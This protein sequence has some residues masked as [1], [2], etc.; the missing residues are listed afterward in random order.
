M[1]IASQINEAADILNRYIGAITILRDGI[2]RTNITKDT[3]QSITASDGIYTITIPCTDT[4]ISN[5]QSMYSLNGPSDI[6]DRVLTIK[7]VIGNISDDSLKYNAVLGAVFKPVKDANGN[8][9]SASVEIHVEQTAV[10]YDDSLNLS[11]ICQ[12]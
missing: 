4:C 8:I 6:K 12:F 7:K 10:Q 2:I 1:D 3:I 9:T 11:I 5:L